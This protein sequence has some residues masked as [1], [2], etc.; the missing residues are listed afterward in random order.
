MNQWIEEERVVTEREI[1]REDDMTRY[2]W[3]Q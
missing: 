3:G 2:K 1:E